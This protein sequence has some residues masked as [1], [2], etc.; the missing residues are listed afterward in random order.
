MENDLKMYL[1]RK[2]FQNI[3][4]P[5]FCQNKINKIDVSFN[6]VNRTDACLM[7][8]PALSLHASDS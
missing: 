8:V 4:W 7:Y 3:T 1:L 2:Y 6:I 5:G